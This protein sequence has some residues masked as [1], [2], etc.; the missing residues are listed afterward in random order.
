M[1]YFLN[2]FSFKGALACFVLPSE[3][4][5]GE[6]TSLGFMF[7]FGF[8]IFALIIYFLRRKIQMAINLIIEASK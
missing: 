4:D 2:V 8:I 1:R 3:N 6:F 7:A 5:R